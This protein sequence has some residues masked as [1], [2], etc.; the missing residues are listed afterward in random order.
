MTDIMPR[1]RPEHLHR[2]TSRH[3][4]VL[5]YYR[6][7]GQKRIRIRGV[8]GSLEFWANLEAAKAAFEAR[9]PLGT[10]QRLAYEIILCTGLRR[11]DVHKFGRQHVK[12]GTYTVR[13]SKTGMVVESMMAPR[14]AQAIATTRTGDMCF[15]VSDTGRPFASKASFGNWFGDACR[16]AG[17]EGSAHGI[18]KA[19]AA[20]AAE[21]GMTEAQLN[22]MFGWSH[23]S[24]ESATYIAKASRAKMASAVVETITRTIGKGEGEHHSQPIEK[25]GKTQ[26]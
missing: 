1:P 6:K 23:G 20:M 2:E 11:G 15:L 19:I 18:R 25:K 14:L 16:A 17:V 21:G 13:T 8:Y 10:M 5:W 22:A 3:G 12:G 26:R 4:T 24:R 9:W 7:P